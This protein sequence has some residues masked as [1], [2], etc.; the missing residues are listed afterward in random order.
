MG[1]NPSSIAGTPVS[2]HFS[3]VISKIEQESV[4]STTLEGIIF[5]YLMVN[6]FMTDELQQDR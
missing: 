4:C 1:I 3:L 2:P 5:D 6:V